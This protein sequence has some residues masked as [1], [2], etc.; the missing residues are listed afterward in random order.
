MAFGDGEVHLPG[1]AAVAE[2]AGDAGAEFGDVE[3]F[4]E[5]HLE[6]GAD[7]GAEGEQ[8]GGVGVLGQQSP[9]AAAL[10][11]GRPG[12]GYRRRAR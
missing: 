1:D 2:V 7:A 4:G 3:G 9:P 5:V 12:S 8:V 10:W 11:M 6:H